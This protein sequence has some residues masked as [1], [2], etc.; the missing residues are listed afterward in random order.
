MTPEPFH[1][2]DAR[3]KSFRLGELRRLQEEAAYARAVLPVGAITQLQSSVGLVQGPPDISSGGNTS[4]FVGAS[5]Y[6]GDESIPNNSSTPLTWSV[7]SFDT[8]G[9]VT[10]PSANIV[11]PQDG[12]Y[13]LIAQVEWD[14]NGT[15]RRSIFISSNINPGPYPTSYVQPLPAT[16]ATIQ[17]CS[18]MLSLVAGEIVQVSVLQDTGGSLTAINFNTLFSISLLGD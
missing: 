18:G 3:G 15:G 16:Y 13:L 1:I 12:K 10:A 17:Q 5:Y 2:L 14:G 8:S 6:A 9:F 11:I 4:T 7:Q